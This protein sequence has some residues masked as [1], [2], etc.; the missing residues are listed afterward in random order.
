MN[1]TIDSPLTRCRHA[2]TLGHSF[3]WIAL[4]FMC[5]G[6]GAQTAEVPLRAQARPPL[7]AQ[8]KPGDKLGLSYEE[9]VTV[10]DPEMRKF[11]DGVLRVYREPGLVG[12]RKATLDALGAKILR[13][14][15][16]NTEGQPRPTFRED[17]APEG[18][19]ARKGWTGHYFYTGVEKRA[20]KPYGL[21]E[22]GDVLHWK[23]RIEM[24]IDHKVAACVDSR[25]VEGY[26]DLYWRPAYSQTFHKPNVLPSEWDRHGVVGQMVATALTPIHPFLGVGMV[27]G[28][29]V[30]IDFNRYI[31]FE[32]MSDD[33]IYD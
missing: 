25:A 15:Y 19:F 8:P 11:L 14:N 16:F 23:F 2:R 18:I 20:P 3:A 12:N 28:C 4:S 32:E 9:A 31:N 33:Q 29:V 10:L 30:R 21:F 7:I 27:G 5:F 17:F 6:V 26:L 1:M 22:P 13:R 24:R